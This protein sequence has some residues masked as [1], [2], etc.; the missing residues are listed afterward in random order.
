MGGEKIFSGEEVQESYEEKRK[1]F[2]ELVK[3]METLYGD[4]AIIKAH[5]EAM[6]IFKDCFGDL[7]RED[8]EKHILFHALIGSSIQG[9]MGKF[10]IDYRDEKAENM[11]IDITTNL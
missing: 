3:K 8:Q 10:V 9:N 5:E 4:E 7:P 1:F 2:M 11:L 6:K